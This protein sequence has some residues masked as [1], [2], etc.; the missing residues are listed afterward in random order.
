MLPTQ[1][2]HIHAAQQGTAS[3]GAPSGQADNNRPKEGS[4]R[5][6]RVL[7]VC[8]RYIYPSSFVGTKP[9]LALSTPQNWRS[10]EIPPFRL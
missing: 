5:W 3:Q 9:N 2:F 10:F 7:L 6:G 8:R 1:T 4:T